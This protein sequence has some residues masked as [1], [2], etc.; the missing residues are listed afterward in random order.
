MKNLPAATL[1]LSLIPL[2]GGC[3]QEQSG[4]VAPVASTETSAP[5]PDSKTV[6]SSVGEPVVI[7]NGRPI[8]KLQFAAMLAEV[9]RKHPGTV[10]TT[11]VQRAMLNEFVTLVVMSQ[12]A[13]AEGLDIK[14]SVQAALE[15][16]RTRT[17][18]QALIAGYL[19]SHPITDE[20]VKQA[21]DEQFGNEPIREYK[22][23][24]ILVAG[25]DDAKSVIAELDKGADFAQLA[26]DRSTGPSGPKG[27]DLGWF[28]PKD[29]VPEFTEAVAG[30][31]KGTYSETPV[32]T[33]FGWH[34]IQLEDVRETQPPAFEAVKAQLLAKLREKAITA[35]AT[36]LRGKAEL[37]PVAKPA[38]TPAP[39]PVPA[40]EASA[41]PDT[42]E[43]SGQ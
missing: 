22:A 10:S 33:K 34:V 4:A 17:L 11:Q 37:K 2:V 38:P 40:P 43:A 18:S 41:K 35:Y 13:E 24:H 28:S 27:G 8:G 42:G 9:E 14:P 7:V 31:E 20:D 15:W 29:M 6:E 21:Y 23:R 16:D 19:T 5:S 36:E 30:M 25:E 32:K 12:E 1:L 39:V 26:K 3:N